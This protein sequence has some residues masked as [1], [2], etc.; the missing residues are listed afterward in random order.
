VKLTRP[1]ILAAGFVG[2]LLVGATSQ[3]I[4]LGITKKQAPPTPVD[5]TL[6]A[7][8]TDTVDD[9]PSTGSTETV[10]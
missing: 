10:A 1:L 7:F 8:L 2:G 3:A 5:D 9:T 6:P 4:R